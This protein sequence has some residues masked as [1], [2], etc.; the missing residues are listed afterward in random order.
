[1]VSIKHRLTKKQKSQTHKKQKSR[2]HKKQKSQTQKS[3][4]QKK[5]KSRQLD[6]KHFSLIETRPYN[7]LSLDTIN[8][9]NLIKLDKETPPNIVGSFKYIVHE[10]PADI[11]MFES[12]KSCCTLKAATKDIVSKFKVIAKNIKESKHIYLGDFKA[13]YDDRYY[14]DIGSTEGSKII[15]YDAERIKKDI[16]KLKKNNLLSL[17]EFNELMEKVVDNPKLQQYYDLESQIK[18]KY[19]IR[20]KLNEMING[21]KTLPLGLDIKLEDALTHKSIVKID[22]WIYLNKRFIEMTNM[23]MLTYDDENGKTHHLSIKPEKYETS[24][25]EDL[26]KYSNRSVNKYM[27]LAK[28]LWVYAVLKDNKKIM[29]HLYPLFSSGASKMYQIAGE[30]ET[31]ENILKNI[32]KP[33]LSSIKS[34]IE[35]W[36]TRLGTVMSDTLPIPVANDIYKKIDNVI[37]NIHNKEY[38]ISTLEEI[39]DTLIIYINKYVKRYLRKKNIMVDNVLADSL[40]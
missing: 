39:S 35:D 32:K 31:I 14:I 18:K 21:T 9:I 5:Q 20:W 29:L 6:D 25:I 1:M 7:S 24:L 38:V 33:L 11:D 40:Y 4:T 12:Y 10:Y 28:R 2:T 16:L 8:A 19:V 15:N 13:G 17:E 34:N 36:K 22:I 26:Q 27:K 37:K 30:I 23:Y 3:Q